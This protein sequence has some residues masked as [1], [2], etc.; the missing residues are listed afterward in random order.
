MFF[1][2]DYY[3]LLFIIFL[4]SIFFKKDIS[5]NFYLK[6]ILSYVFFILSFPISKNN[7]WYLDNLVLFNHRGKD[8]QKNLTILQKKKK[9]I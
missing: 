1:E 9:I 7:N 4:P 2:Y 6:N 3:W 5:P 8:I